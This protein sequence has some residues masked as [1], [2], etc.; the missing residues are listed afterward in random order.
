MKPI[1]TT[2]LLNNP[3]FLSGGNAKEVYL[4]VQL[5]AQEVVRT[6]KRIPLNLCLVIDR[7]GS[8]DGDKM[9]YAKKAADFVINQL[10]QDDI[11]SIVQYDNIIEVIHA[12]EKLKNKEVIHQKV[13]T[14]KARNMTN[15]SGG[16]M[17][18]YNQVRK[19]KAQEQVNRVLLLSDGLANE[20]ITDP[21]QLNL[22]AKK[23]F[24]TDAIGLSTF[25]VGADY[26]EKL[27]TNL[28]EN[29]GGNYYFIDSPDKIPTIFA[30]ELTGLLTVLAQNARLSIPIPSTH[31]H[32][33]KCMAIRTA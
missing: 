15:L 18:G 22:I 4:Y 2:F 12:A 21:E 26:N 27:M 13:A 24:E 20:G 6:D 33:I 25:G 9:T 17:E 31:F 14:I 10:D 23:V 30:E 1:E 7:S 11:L 5:N 32:V 3:Y 8:M 28:S 16:M 19:L 29:G